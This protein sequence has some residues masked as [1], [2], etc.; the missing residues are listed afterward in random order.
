VI[1][2]ERSLL[3]PFVTMKLVHANALLIP[4]KLLMKIEI[5]IIRLTIKYF[6]VKVGEKVEMGAAKEG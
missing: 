3:A 6:W 2:I 5:R 1:I 4:N